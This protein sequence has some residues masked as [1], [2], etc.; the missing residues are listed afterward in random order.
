M[1]VESLRLKADKILG[2]CLSYSWRYVEV[3]QLYPRVFVRGRCR[4]DFSVVI[5]LAALFFSWFVYIEKPYIYINIKTFY[6]DKERFRFFMGF[7]L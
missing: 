6:Y 7:C 5:N 3:L 1:K 2:L 4:K